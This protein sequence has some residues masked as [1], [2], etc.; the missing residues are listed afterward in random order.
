MNY[1]KKYFQFTETISGTAYFLRNVL[2]GILAYLTGVGMGV[3][4]IQNDI[5]ILLLS[6]LAFVFV[7][8]F[9]MTTVYK[10]FNALTPKSANINTIGL[11]SAQLFATILPEPYSYIITILLVIVAIFLIFSNSYLENHKG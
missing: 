8:W 11:L 5:T 7:Y 9:G 10:R 1:I 3:A 6:A 4:M 2:V